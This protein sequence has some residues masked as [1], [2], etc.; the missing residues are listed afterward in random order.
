M[1]LKSDRQARLA[2]ARRRLREQPP[3]RPTQTTLPPA[4]ADV[5]QRDL[6]RSLERMEAVIGR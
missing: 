1:S 5:D 6:K 3:G 2:E 4:N